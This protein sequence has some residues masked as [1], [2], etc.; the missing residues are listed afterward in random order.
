MDGRRAWKLMQVV[1]DHQDSTTTVI[2]HKDGSIEF[3][4]RFSNGHKTDGDHFVAEI[5][6]RSSSSEV[7]VVGS[8]GAGVNA[9]FGGKTR[10][11]TVSQVL[12]ID[13]AKVAAI[14]YFEAR[15]YQKDTKGEFGFFIEYDD[16]KGWKIKPIKDPVKDTK[17]GPWVAMKKVDP[18][19]L[20]SNE[21]K[22]KPGIDYTD[23]DHPFLH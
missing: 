17:P 4:S 1:G 21:W 14:S 11:V 15:H 12:R 19:A 22:P 16:K 7:L 6:G 9:S 8:Q 18:P 13:E 2:T 23:K 20:P 3:I 5:V 10:V